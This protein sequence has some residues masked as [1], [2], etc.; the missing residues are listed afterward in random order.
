MTDPTYRPPPVAAD[1][2]G[3]PE[4]PPGP[5][6]IVDSEEVS[7]T[8]VLSPHA[9]RVSDAEAELLVTS[10]AG[11]GPV[12]ASSRVI[13]GSVGVI[14]IG[15]TVLLGAWLGGW[16]TEHGE[17]ALVPRAVVTPEGEWADEAADRAAERTDRAPAEIPLI[18]D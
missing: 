11:A 8:P 3:E 7:Q 2:A 5:H 10:A 14:L 18:R 4:R 1:P 15:L 6:G 17:R 12:W 16:L 13:A 9:D